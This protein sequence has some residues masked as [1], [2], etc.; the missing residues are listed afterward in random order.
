MKEERPHRIF[1]LAERW[2]PLFIGYRTM[3]VLALG[4]P[5]AWRITSRVMEVTDEYLSGA[6]R[7]LVGI[8]TVLVLAL[9]ISKAMSGLQ[10]RLSNG[11]SSI[12]PASRYMATRITR[13]DDEENEELGQ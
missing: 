7:P 12:Y 11:Y 3:F 5:L 2:M 10:T 8:F 13:P 9:P 6:L 4:Y 1:K